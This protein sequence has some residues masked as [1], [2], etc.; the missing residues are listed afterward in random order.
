VKKAARKAKK[1]KKAAKKAKKA[2]KKAKKVRHNKAKR[3]LRKM[4]PALCHP[5]RNAHRLRKVI[6]H[7]T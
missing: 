2:T 7:S 6:K 1:A 5:R 4:T 3:Q